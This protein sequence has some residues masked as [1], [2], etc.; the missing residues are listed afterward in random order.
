MW[1]TRIAWFA[2]GVAAGGAV[3]DALASHG[4]SVQLTGTVA[5]WIGWGAVA[6]ALLV[7]SVL[8][9]TI[10]RTAVPV[11]AVVA[12][13]VLVEGGEV[14]TIA[15]FAG[16]AAIACAG[17]A[18]G[19]LGQFFVQAS[20]Y[21]DEHRF[22]L[23]PPVAYLVPTVVSWCVWCAAVVLAPLLLAAEVWAAGIPVAALAIG[24]TWFL[25]RRFHRLSRRWLVLVPAGVVVHDHLVLG[26]TAMFQ[27]RTVERIRLALADTEA[28]DLTGPAAGHAV[29]IV[30]TDMPTVVLAA[31]PSKP[32]GTA[33][34]VRSV[35]V[36]PTRPGRALTAAARRLPVG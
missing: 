13:I 10:V 5:A 28:A 8:G 11:A 7:P 36:A 15:L 33:L 30:F 23:R 6:A 14:A 26:E 21:G 18:T 31:T 12:V 1:G 35:L 20:A 9:L 27:H 19:E 22:L 17:V 2:L 32:A 29:E 3:G 16:C 34:H 4:R 25:G 24:L